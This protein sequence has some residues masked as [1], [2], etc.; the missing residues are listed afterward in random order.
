MVRGVTRLM[1]ALEEQLMDGLGTVVLIGGHLV[2]HFDVDLVLTMAELAALRMIG[3]MALT[4]A[5]GVLIMVEIEA[6]NMVD[7]VGMYIIPQPPFQLLALSL[8]LTTLFSRVFVDSRSPI[9]RS[10]T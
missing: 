5:A 7:F 6:L 2:L 9:R 1:R 4:N 3:I 8:K 10:R